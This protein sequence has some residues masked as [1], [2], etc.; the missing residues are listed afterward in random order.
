MIEGYHAPGRHR[1]E[2]D[3]LRSQAGDFRHAPTRMLV[4]APLGQ[5]T[6][7]FKLV[8]L[9]VQENDRFNSD[10]WSLQAGH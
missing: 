8:S 5:A 2:A 3:R 9:L 7:I 6:L 10:A 4:R 1:P